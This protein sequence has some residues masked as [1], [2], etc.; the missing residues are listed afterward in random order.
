MYCYVLAS[1]DCPDGMAVLTD[2][3]VVFARTIM[4]RCHRHSR[5]CRAVWTAT[6]RGLD[7]VED[8]CVGMRPE[9]RSELTANA[10]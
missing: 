1:E 6:I 2:E 3:G 7:Y 8:G 9:G 4:T 5:E 10:G